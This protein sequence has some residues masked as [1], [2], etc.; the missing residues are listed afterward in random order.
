MKS[1]KKH[2][3]LNVKSEVIYTFSF[4]SDCIFDIKKKI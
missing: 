2:Y 3:P 4:S 1:R